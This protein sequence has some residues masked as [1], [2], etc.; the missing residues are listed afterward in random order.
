MCNIAVIEFFIEHAK[1]KEFA[2]KKVLEVGSRY[3]NGSVRPLIE[4]FLN[5][6]EYIGIDIEPGMFVDLVIPAERLLDNFGPAFFDVVIATEL[7]EHVRD[8]RLVI[9]N[10]K[11]VLKPKGYIYITTRSRGFPY[12][13]YPYDFWRFEVEDMKAIFSDFEIKCLKRDHIAPGVFLKA[14]KPESWIPADLNNIA[15]YSVLLGRKTKE[16]V[17]RD[18]PFTRSLVLKF[19]NSKARLLADL[20]IP[21]ALAHFLEKRFIE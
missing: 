2:N 1:P 7:L 20:L 18:I 5:P 15:L 6:K 16:I 10:M 9:S 19:R 12:H 14:R 8:W 17:S 4:K 21:R 11:R 13:G 3:I